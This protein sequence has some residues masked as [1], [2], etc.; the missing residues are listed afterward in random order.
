MLE[1]LNPE[2]GHFQRE[3]SLPA[4]A[5]ARKHLL[6]EDSVHLGLHLNVEGNAREM[7]TS[8]DWPPR[9][10]CGLTRHVLG[11]ERLVHVFFA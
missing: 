9:W 7:R 2:G 3:R 6:L 4:G 1:V 8:K 5:R 11:E 10:P